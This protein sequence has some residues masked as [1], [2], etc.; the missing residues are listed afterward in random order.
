[1]RPQR[2]LDRFRHL[3]EEAGVPRITVHELR[4][5]AATLTITV[6]VP[7]TVVSKMLRHSTLSR[8]RTFTGT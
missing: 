4:H 3:S 5:L 8:P 6:G 2:V 7:L 1:M